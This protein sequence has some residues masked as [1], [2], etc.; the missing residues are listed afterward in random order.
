MRM[1]IML[2]I[3]TSSSLPRLSCCSS[4]SFSFQATCYGC[5]D[6]IK[7]SYDSEKTHAKQFTVQREKYLLLSF[8][9]SLGLLDLS[10]Q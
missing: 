2:V 8:L 3:S 9:L 10:L 1:A 7:V 4:A 5:K 6:I